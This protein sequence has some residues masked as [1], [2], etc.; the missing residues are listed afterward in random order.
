MPYTRRAGVRLHYQDAGSGPAVLLHTGG[1][2]DGRMWDLAGYT[3]ALAG[4]RTLVL[5]NLAGTQAEMFALMLEAWASEPASWSDFPHV[6]APALV[7]CGENEEPAAAH[8]AQLAAAAMP[9]GTAVVLPGLW[10]LQAFWRTD[11]TLPPLTSFL[12]Q[13]IG[14]SQQT[15]P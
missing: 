4:Y 5:D 11:Q 7:I 3:A 9:H 10:H 12:R 2:G 6:Q 14:R 1:G 15:A 13:H 8:H